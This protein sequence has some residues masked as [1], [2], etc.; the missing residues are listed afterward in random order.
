[1]AAY[2]KKIAVIG[3]GGRNQE[4]P[5]HQRFSDNYFSQA[6]AR[7]DRNGIAQTVTTCFGNPGSGRFMHYRDLRSITVREAAR[8]QSFPDTCVFEGHHSTQM[9]HI[10]NAVPPL[11]ARAIRD[12]LAS[13]L[14]AYFARLAEAKPGRPKISTPS[15]ERSRVMRAVQSTD[16]S[17]EV[18][19]RQA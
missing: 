2:L 16:T 10:G 3:E 19:L 6:Y 7:L 17:P 9:R 14:R 15:A 5:D 18:L 8:F 12:Q 1:S 4:L 13:D 11:L